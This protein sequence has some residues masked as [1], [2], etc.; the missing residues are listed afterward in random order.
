MSLGRL[1]L[2]KLARD[3]TGR[4]SALG[5]LCTDLDAPGPY[6]QDLGPIFSQCSP[7]AWLIRYIYCVTI[8]YSS[9]EYSR[10]LWL[11][12]GTAQHFWDWGGGGRLNKM[13]KAFLARAAG[14]S[15]LAGSR[16]MLP[17]KI[18]KINASRMAKNTSQY[19]RHSDLFGYLSG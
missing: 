7:R 17:R 5:L 3:R 19:C 12:P 14:A 18:F 2:T 6:C 15:V 8:T 1:W 13:P 10:M 9:L 11:S 4:I 16:G